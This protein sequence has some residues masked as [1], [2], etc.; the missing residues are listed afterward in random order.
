MLMRKM[1][2]LKAVLGCM[3][4]FFV[5]SI[6]ALALVNP[7]LAV[8]PIR[9]MPDGSI[10]PSNTLIERNGDLYTFTGN[11]YSQI[12][13]DRDN[14]V[15]DGAGF[16]LEGTYNGTRTDDWSVGQGPNQQTSTV[17]W[18]IGIDAA[19]KNR[20]NMT[21]A[22]LNIKNFYIGVYVWTSN[23][24]IRGNYISGNIVGILLSGDSNKIAGNYIAGNEEGI[25]FGVNNPGN[26]P[27]NIVLVNNSFVDNKVNFSGCFCEAYNASEPVHT[28][29]DGKQGNYWSNYNGSD[30]NGDGFGDSPYVI[31][32]MNI[33][34]YPFMRSIAVPPV[35]ADKLPVEIIVLSVS[36]STL[37]ISGFFIYN[38]RLRRKEAI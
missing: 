28:W 35:R 16:A 36:G 5:L 25:F 20:R 33:D 34:R 27:L 7:V 10:Q 18:T 32:Q 37:G 8:S 22:N 4:A 30:T 15:I 19:N 29:D 26:L 14:V 31:D 2:R 9:I 1:I 21:I 12:V 23:N 11:V 6:S 38:K 3:L 13:V 24:T 17:P